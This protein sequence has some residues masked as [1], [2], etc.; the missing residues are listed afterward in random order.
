MIYG[1]EK[2]IGK[3]VRL[4]ETYK[5]LLLK[6]LK[7]GQPNHAK[8]FGHSVGIVESFIDYGPEVDVR[9][10]PT[11][12]RYA[13]HPD[14]LEVL[15]NITIQ[16]PNHYWLGHCI[17]NSK[18]FDN[19]L[20]TTFPNFDG[21]NK[22]DYELMM[23]FAEFYQ[24]GADYFENGKLSGDDVAA[25]LRNHLGQIWLD[26]WHFESVWPHSVNFGELCY[27]SDPTINLEITWKFKSVYPN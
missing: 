17:L 25:K 11:Q 27:S 3:T 8:E 26:Q 23:V 18:S 20:I 2:L 12:L 22:K 7:D 13:Y 21:N 5:Q 9:W 15:N 14:H 19:G 16:F 4:T 6:E 10:Q 1:D 24:F